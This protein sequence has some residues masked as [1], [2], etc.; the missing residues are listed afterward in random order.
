MDE[1][2]KNNNSDTTVVYFCFHCTNFVIYFSFTFHVLK[3]VNST[4]RPF[5]IRTSDFGCEP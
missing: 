4:D 1:S 2:E 3:G 5:G